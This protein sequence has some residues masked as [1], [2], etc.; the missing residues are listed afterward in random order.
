MSACRPTFEIAE[1]S[2]SNICWTEIEAQQL[3]L[4][5]DCKVT[6]MLYNS[7]YLSQMFA[8]E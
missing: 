1:P 2:E 5:L 7:N 3:S 8:N 4:H 6:T